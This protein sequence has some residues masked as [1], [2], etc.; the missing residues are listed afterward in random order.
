MMTLMQL[1]DFLPLQ[2]VHVNINVQSK[3]RALEKVSEVAAASLN[4]V[5]LTLPILE[6]LINRERLGSTGLGHGVAIPHCRFAGISDPLIILLSLENGIDFQGLDKQPVDIIL[7]LLVPLES[8]DLHLQLLAWI[9]EQFSK[10]QVLERIRSAQNEQTL[11]N[12][13]A[14]LSDE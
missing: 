12:I 14:N 7:A 4:N 6:G 8:N 3:K 1:T 11:Y 9:A 10:P 13:M 5:K 2:N